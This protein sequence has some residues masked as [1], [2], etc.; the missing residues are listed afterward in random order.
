MHHQGEES[1][2]LSRSGSAANRKAAE[3]AQCAIERGACRLRVSLLTVDVESITQT[4][5]TMDHACCGLIRLRRTVPERLM[6]EPRRRREDVPAAAID[7]TIIV[8]Q[9]VQ[10]WSRARPVGVGSESLPQTWRL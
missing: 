4:S 5:V 7:I 3:A 1:Y 2:L 10:Y 6:G 9:K 8:R